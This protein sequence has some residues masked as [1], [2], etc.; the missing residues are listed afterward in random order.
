MKQMEWKLD[1]RWR[2]VLVGIV[3]QL[4]GDVFS[5]VC[6]CRNIRV[7]T[8]LNPREVIYSITVPSTV[9]Q[10]PPLRPI[11]VVDVLI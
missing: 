2:R 7:A 1:E 3:G 8:E 11:V 4:E 6:W 10:S 9:K 5:R